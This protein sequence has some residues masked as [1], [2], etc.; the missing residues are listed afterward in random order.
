MESN[1]TLEPAERREAVAAEKPRYA[2]LQDYLRV[3]RRNWKIV[4]LFTVALTGLGLGISL[5]QSPTYEATASVGYTEVQLQLGPLSG[6]QSSLTVAP[7]IRSAQIA[8]EVTS[9]QITRRAKRSLKTKLSAKELQDSVSAAVSLTTNLVEITAKASTAKLAVRIADAYAEQTA[10]QLN[11]D[12]AA[13]LKGIAAEL[14]KQI[15]AAPKSPS[16]AFPGALISGLKAQLSRIRVAQTAP[17]PARVAEKATP[18]PTA[19]SPATT[20]NTIIGAVLGLVFGLLAAF[21]RDSLDRR[22]HSAHEIHTETGMPILGRV[23]QSVLGSPGLARNGGPPMLDTDF[24]SFRTLRANLGVLGV[25]PAVRLLLVTSGLPE[26]GKTTVSISLASA[27]ALTGQRVLLVE[28]DLRRPTFAKRMGISRGPG[29]TEYLMGTA[30]PQEI[31][32]TVSLVTPAS[33]TVAPGAGVSGGALVCITAGAP[34]ANPAELLVSPRFKQM[35]EKLRKAYD[36]VV[37]DSGPILAVVDPLELVPQVDGVLV[38]VRARS[39]TR[40]QARATRLALAN[41]PARP[42]GAVITG[43]SRGDPDSYDYYYGD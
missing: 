34:V 8:Q 40:D 33:P 30:D 7:Q 18:P 24:E 36:L 14:E 35:L 21:A 11:H 9:P 23:S 27:A 31:L 32:Q 4:A 25:D 15:K 12:Y 16:P 22:L 42:T 41:L 10:K 2:T 1:V 20:R 3:V 29:M 28:C 26:E 39:T 43:I 17:D 5:A 37:I 6:G 13:Q 19:S 38:C